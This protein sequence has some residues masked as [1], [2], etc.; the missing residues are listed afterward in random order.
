M[1]DRG[2]LDTADFGATG[3]HRRDCRRNGAVLMLALGR[4]VEVR[5]GRPQ[6]CLGSHLNP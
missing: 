3:A 5:A 2:T 6:A 4:P 1:K